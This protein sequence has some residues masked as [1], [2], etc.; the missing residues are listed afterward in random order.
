MNACERHTVDLMLYLDDELVGGKL[1]DF[2]A[3][4]KICADCRASL[5][6]QLALSAVLR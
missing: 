3:H 5:E 2:L 1:M 4:L 6:E